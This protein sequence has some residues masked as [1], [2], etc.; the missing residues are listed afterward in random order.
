MKQKGPADQAKKI[1]KVK[2]QRAKR[3][4]RKCQNQGGLGV[5]KLIGKCEADRERGKYTIPSQGE[6]KKIRLMK[7]E[8]RKAE[9]SVERTKLLG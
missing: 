8:I 7:R 4:E 1:A 6:K 9:R 3:A 2:N 5:E